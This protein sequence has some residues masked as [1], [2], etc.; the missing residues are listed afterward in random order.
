MMVKEKF[1]ETDFVVPAN[2]G[3]LKQK[4]GNFRFAL[5]KLTFLP[6]ESSK[7]IR[8]QYSYPNI[9][10][11]ISTL[12]AI[13]EADVIN[14][15]W[16]NKGYLSFRSLRK[17]FQLGKPIVWTLHDMWA[18][19]GGCHYAGECSNYQQSCGNCFYL[20]NPKPKDIS[21]LTWAKK[22]DIYKKGNLHI[23]TCSEWLA[24]VARSSSL[25]SN[26]SVQSI[27]NTLD[28]QI[29]KPESNKKNGKYTILFQSMNINDKRKGLKY[30]LEALQIIET[31][32]PD[33]AKQMELLIF[34]KNTASAIDDLSYTTSYLGV[35]KE[36]KDI[37]AAYNK[38]DIFVI[39]SL[40]DNLPNTI[41]ESLA[42]GVPV[43]GFETGG[44]PEMV[45]HL[46]NGYIAQQKD[47]KAL[48]EGII[49]TISNK[50]RYDTLSKAA[51][52]KV[53][54]AY[55]QKIVAS[56]YIQ[57]YKSILS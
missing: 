14:L 28:T 44:I 56:K 24:N 19:T 29:F 3:K 34:G 11:D 13:Q 40:A 47:A 48:A 30:F 7:E 33:I 9:G 1:G 8:F 52:A 5:E 38:S 10:Q 12:S 16:I 21:A 26:T 53:H 57:V 37:A 36:Q 42:C 20:K 2:K 39:P 54:T 23:V 22:Q 41:M 43:V 51:V 27:P 50:E 49:W 15:H 18:F 25:L 32:H 31:S 46:V 35:L 4:L 55:T 6:Y 45:D 17:L